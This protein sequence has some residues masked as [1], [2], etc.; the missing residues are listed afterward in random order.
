M[1]KINWGNLVIVS[2]AR[3]SLGTI[4]SEAW[5]VWEIGWAGSVPSGTYGIWN[6]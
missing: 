3:L 6:Y 5:R 1:Q 2:R 4:P